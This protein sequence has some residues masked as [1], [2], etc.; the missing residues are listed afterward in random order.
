M[1][2][3]VTFE[4]DR[5]WKDQVEMWLLR[6]E[7]GLIRAFSVCWEKRFWNFEWEGKGI[8]IK[9]E[10]R[11]QPGF[12]NN[13]V[14]SAKLQEDLEAEIQDHTLKVCRWPKLNLHNKGEITGRRL[15][16]SK[17]TG[18]GCGSLIQ[19]AGIVSVCEMISQRW[20]TSTHCGFQKKKNSEGTYIDILSPSKDSL[21]TAVIWIYS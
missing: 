20:M 7:C 15:W 18:A 12:A 14:I 17:A 4:F 1:N 3:G 13:K 16:R 2:S 21:F 11:S 5:E 6:R 9:R 10:D 8:S 19:E